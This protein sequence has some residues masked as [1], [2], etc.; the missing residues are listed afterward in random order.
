MCTLT[1]SLCVRVCICAYIFAYKRECGVI[2][3]HFYFVNN[4]YYPPEVIAARV[5]ITL[6]CDPNHVSVIVATST[7]ASHVLSTTSE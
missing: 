7:I 2:Y 4:L 5:I 1:G 6:T 3:I